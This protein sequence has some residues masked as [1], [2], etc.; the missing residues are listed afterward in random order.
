MYVRVTRGHVNPDK[1]DEVQ[2]V[3]EEVL[4]PALQQLPGFRGYRGGVNRSTG[5]VV[6]ISFWDTEEQSLALQSRRGPL[7]DAGAELDPAE[8]YEI[9]IDFWEERKILERADIAAM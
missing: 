2:R 1:F 3:V 4:K 8:T 7:E 6:G 9:T 5:A